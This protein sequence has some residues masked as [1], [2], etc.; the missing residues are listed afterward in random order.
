L[1]LAVLGGTGGL[2][3]ACVERACAA[4]HA[5]RVL[6]RNPGRVA[7]PPGVEVVAGDV[8]DPEALARAIESC[9]VVFYCVNP[10][11]TAW[12]EHL[13][14]L[15]DRALEACRRTGARFVFPANVWVFGPG[16]GARVD[17]QRAYAPVAA[18]GVL[19]L[20]QERRIRDSGVPHTL[21]RLPEFYGPNVTTLLEA[22]FRNALAGWPLSWIGPLDREAELVLMDDAATAM[23]VV[24]LA[25]DAVDETF[26]LP[27]PA[28]IRMRDFFAE[29][30]QQAGSR[31]LVFEVPGPALAVAGWFSALARVG[32][33]VRPLWTHPTLLDGSKYRARF[34]D[35]PA[36]PYA[37]GIRRTLSWLRAH[38]R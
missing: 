17:E 18:R 1:K 37:E 5:V 7:L 25:P 8:A 28:A 34:G 6:A 30:L 27:G 12:A 26:H 23:L 11:I 13:L 9:E 14:P 4:G 29:L 32:Q 21:L 24:G 2:G 10:P 3:L 15:T 31:S 19:R 38:P 35:L 20:A 36:T 33:D 16:D 22:P